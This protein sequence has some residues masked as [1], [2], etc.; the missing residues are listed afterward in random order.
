MRLSF[1]GRESWELLQVA[2][3]LFRSPLSCYD[4]IQRPGQ[5]SREID[6]FRNDVDYFRADIEILFLN[7]QPDFELSSASFQR[8]YEALDNLLRS[9][10]SLLSESILEINDQAS[11]PASIRTVPRKIHPS[12]K[13]RKIKLDTWKSIRSHFSKPQAPNAKQTPKSHT[14]TPIQSRQITASIEAI[15]P[16]ALSKLSSLKRKIDLSEKRGEVYKDWDVCVRPLEGEDYVKM[17]QDI[18]TCNKVMELVFAT[19]PDTGFNVAASR[20]VDN[21]SVQDQKGPY[22]L[23]RDLMRE[24][25]DSLASRLVNCKGEHNAK[26]HLP[27]SCAEVYKEQSFDLDIYL[28]TCA[29]PYRWQW[30]KVIVRTDESS[31]AGKHSGVQSIC[32]IV[33]KSQ[34]CGVSLDLLSTGKNLWDLSSYREKPWH[35]NVYPSVSLRCL[36]DYGYFAQTRGRNLPKVSLKDKRALAVILA[37]NM[38]QLC[39]GPWIREAWNADN[40]FF[41]YDPAAHQILNIR[42]PYIGSLIELG[43]FQSLNVDLGDRVHRYPLILDFAR[44]LLEIQNGETII[45]VSE[46]YH[47]ITQEETSNTP[48]YMVNRILQEI[49]NDIFQDYRDAIDA[50]L[51]LPRKETTFDDLK[52]RHYIY[53]YVVAPLEDEL[54]KGFKT[55]VGELRTAYQN[56]NGNT[57]HKLPGVYL[58]ETTEIHF[59]N[60]PP[61]EPTRVSTSPKTSNHIYQGI[62]VPDT[63]LQTSANNTRISRFAVET[64]HIS[65]TISPQDLYGIAIICPMGIELVPILAILDEEHVALPFVGGRLRNKY[66]LGRIGEHNVV[67]TVMPETGNNAAAA[68]VTQLQNDFKSLRFGLLVGI[69]GGVPDLDKNDI[70]LGDVVVSKPTMAFGGVVQFDRGK[71]NAN[72]HFERT[73]ALNKPPPV[74][75]ASLEELIARHTL[76][77]NNLSSHLMAM[78]QKH[79]R[80]VEKNYIYQG[81]QHDFLFDHDYAHAGGT[82]SCTNCDASRIIKRK[83]RGSKS[84][85]VHYGTIGSSNI[86][87][88]D[89]ETRERLRRELGIMCVDMEAAGL[90][91]EF[92]CLVIRGICDYSDSHKTK[93]WQPYAAA[94]AAAFA[95]E[96]LSIVP[97]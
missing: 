83:P 77:G 93:I 92:P 35:I 21:G 41:R 66:T 78:T 14:E 58:S 79:P 44:L 89:A 51:A 50:C 33:D 30:M 16:P 84:P 5:S 17:L 74:L 94:T 11:E 96:L 72:N 28:S 42:Q 71:V 25:H 4:Y 10:D 3:R 49:S 29:V 87:I 65:T 9:F 20:M 55:K 47:A 43:G 27:V 36:L 68:V 38:L 22:Y 54:Y 85:K 13:S 67:V 60:G 40:I 48:F 12:D 97:A 37:H 52:F 61:K 23:T 15:G 7:I 73:G 2:G 90:I 32:D 82:A 6:K 81:E 69:G 57:T 75:M 19:T 53:K 91:N 34:G 46:D 24:F 18:G 26:L 59:S 63:N 95:K 39:G 8:C 80:L 56:D 86:V 62:V 1:E 45:P 64:N 88:K 76:Y 31:M 70:Q